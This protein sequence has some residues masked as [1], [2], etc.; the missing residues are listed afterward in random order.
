MLEEA[1]LQQAAM[2]ESREMD[3]FGVIAVV[4]LF[5]AGFATVVGYCRGRTGDALTL[6]SLLGP[7]G[8]LLTFLFL[9]PTYEAAPVVIKINE[10]NR[11]GRPESDAPGET[12][13]RA[14]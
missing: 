12:F 9:H 5:S 3:F 10:G 14:A 2:T 7:I 4:W 6:G 1:T 13:R 8:L 11:A